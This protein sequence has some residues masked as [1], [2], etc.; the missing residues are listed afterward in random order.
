MAA[1]VRDIDSMSLL[2]CS[3]SVLG[4][5]CQQSQGTGCLDPGHVKSAGIQECAVPEWSCMGSLQPPLLT[6]TKLS[7]PGT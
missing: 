5:H 6:A 3:G 2:F 1:G 4:W 7:A